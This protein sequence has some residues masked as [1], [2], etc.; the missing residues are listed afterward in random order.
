MVGWDRLD[1]GVLEV[2]FREGRVLASQPVHSCRVVRGV[3]CEPCKGTV[4][5]FFSTVCS[6]VAQLPSS[7]RSV[8][9]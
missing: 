6:G 8:Q 4:L 9:H 3:Y 7:S 5:F 2:T 1:G